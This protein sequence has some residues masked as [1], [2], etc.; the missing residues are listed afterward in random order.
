[1][2]K[3]DRIR[4]RTRLL[5]SYVVAAISVGIAAVITLKLGSAGRNATGEGGAICN[6]RVTIALSDGGGIICGAQS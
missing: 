1:M 5:S 3:S 2:S 4:T 6:L